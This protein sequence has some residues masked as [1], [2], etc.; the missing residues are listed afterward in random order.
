MK[1]GPIEQI[2]IPADVFSTSVY[3]L[4]HLTRTT[5]FAIITHRCEK[6]YGHVI[7]LWLLGCSC[8]TGGFAQSRVLF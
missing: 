5:K 8:D 7:V 1:Q 6:V 2:L 3:T 4:V